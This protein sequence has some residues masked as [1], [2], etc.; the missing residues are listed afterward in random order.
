[1]GLR[2]YGQNYKITTSSTEDPE[3]EIKVKDEDI[4]AK[5]RNR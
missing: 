4:E 1:M 5:K 2:S 3:G